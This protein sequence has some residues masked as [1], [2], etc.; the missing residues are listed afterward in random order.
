M[1]LFSKFGQIL[2]KTIIYQQKGFMLS[3]Y[4]AI[5]SHLESKDLKGNLTS[6]DLKIAKVYVVDV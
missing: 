4:V 6:L 5:V 3:Y 1:S 2:K